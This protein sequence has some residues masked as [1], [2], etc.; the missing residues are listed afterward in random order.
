[1]LTEAF[2]A[3]VCLCCVLVYLSARLLSRQ[4]PLPYLP[5]GVFIMGGAVMLTIV[6]L[7]LIVMHQFQ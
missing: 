3:F 4:N 5:A 7:T 6:M 2:V 1:M